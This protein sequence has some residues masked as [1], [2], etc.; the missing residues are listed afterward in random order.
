MGAGSTNYDFVL[1]LLLNDDGI[2]GAEAK[3]K[4]FTD[5]LEP[6]KKK[7]AELEKQNKKLEGQ[8]QRTFNGMVSGALETDVAM[9]FLM[10]TM[11]KS[12]KLSDEYAVEQQKIVALYKLQK[13]EAA[14]V[15]QEVRALN[16]AQTALTRRGSRARNTAQ[17]LSQF[18]TASI[19]G[20]SAII[21]GLIAEATAY[22]RKMGDA[23]ADTAKFNAQLERMSAARG[24][25]DAV[26]TSAVL[27]LLEKAADVSERAANLVAKN[28]EIANF[29]LGVGAVLVTLGALSKIASSGFKMYADVTLSAAQAL[30]LQAAKLQLQ[31]SVNQL[32]A[33]GS[34]GVTGSL[35][36][37]AAPATA[38]AGAGKFLASTILPL[39]AGAII[40]KELVN[41]IQRAINAEETTWEE[42]GQT[43]VQGIQLPTK[44]LLLG[45]RE[46]G[47]VS[48]ETAKKINDL[49]NS[50]FGVGDSL[51]ELAS[52]FNDTADAASQTSLSL[53]DNKNKDAVVDAYSTMMQELENITKAYEKRAAD[54][55]QDASNDALTLASNT[56]KS[57]SA[58]NQRASDT[59][60]KLLSDFARASAQAE[61]QY[62]SQR[63]NII[64][65]GGVEVRRIEERK[66]EELRKLARDFSRTQKDLIGERD[67]LG[68]ALTQEKY[69]EQVSEI[70]RT[71][72]IE[73]R[74]RRED[75]A[76]RLSDLAASY[77]AER[78]QR[79]EALLLQIKENE[80][81]R[82][83]EIKEQQVE[84]AEQLKMIEKNR[85]E[86]L[87]QLAEEQQA[88]RLRVRENFLAK[89]RDLDASLI[90]EQK[91][92]RQ[93]YAAMLRD[94]EQFLNQYRQQMGGNPTRPSA[95]PTRPQMPTPYSSGGY[96]GHG[97]VIQT[98]GR[99]F[100]TDNS[101]T[102]ALESLL[103][104]ELSQKALLS[105]VARGTSGVVWND[106]RKFSG[107][108]T[109]SMKREVRRDTLETLDTVLS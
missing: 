100:I 86:K 83:A 19:A 26:I 58:I 95:P 16:V 38:M 77:A 33:A 59:Q 74:Q 45:L 51:K 48:P 105:A 46:L 49:Q 79:R 90:G 50:I 104:S 24:R 27:P 84:F 41:A 2:K 28:P 91:L 23:T 7:M 44:F 31:A 88:E 8:T 62:N 10:K 107:E 12:N 60:S 94:A 87:R 35:V 55:A 13:K 54:I 47:V 101:T 53:K 67:A 71:S 76:I 22:S 17:S 66:Q 29:A 42:I 70:N 39:T 15:A 5:T 98:H 106:R 11:E 102:K 4:K 63:A 82:V 37:S 103:G 18:G 25:V 30:G 108:Y 73:I 85:D 61:R 97:Q 93:Y 36:G 40:G 9:A 75:I 64:R 78:A 20:G 96:A 72:D 6:I 43:V 52:D 56:A 92:K 69:D 32:A 3:A 65:D 1:R 14:E 80:D 109:T 99:E 34:K 57:I 68:L 81:R 89:I 21:G